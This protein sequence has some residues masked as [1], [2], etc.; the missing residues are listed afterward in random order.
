MQGASAYL[1]WGTGTPVVLVMDMGMG[2]GTGDERRGQGM[3]T[4]P[5]GTGLGRV[6]GPEAMSRVMEGKGRAERSWGGPPAQGRGSDSERTR[7]GRGKEGF[8]SG[9]R[10]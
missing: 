9:Q 4:G 1:M 7:R 3:G 2:T 5:T 10:L 6:W 8:H